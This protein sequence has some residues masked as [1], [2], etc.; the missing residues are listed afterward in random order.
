MPESALSRSNSLVQGVGIGRQ[1]VG[2]G[3]GHWD[4]LRAA[5]AGGGGALLGRGSCVVVMEAVVR[6]EG[7]EKEMLE[8]VAEKK[9]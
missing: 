3:F 8:W 9:A 5:L 2:V 1:E 6:E 4:G 7:G